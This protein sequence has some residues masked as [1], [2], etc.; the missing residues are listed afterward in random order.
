MTTQLDIPDWIGQLELLNQWLIHF[1]LPE[2]YRERTTYREFRELVRAK[3]VELG[4]TPEI[5]E[6]LNRV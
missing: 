6:Q 5:I 4:L 1:P 2:E 3:Q